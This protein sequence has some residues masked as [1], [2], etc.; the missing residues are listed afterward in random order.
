MSLGASSRWIRTRPTVISPFRSARKAQGQ[1]N[2]LARSGN[3]RSPGRRSRNTLCYHGDHYGKSD[4]PDIGRR[5]R[6]GFG[7]TGRDHCSHANPSRCLDLPRDIN[8]IRHDLA[9]VGGSLDEWSPPGQSMTPDVLATVVN[10]TQFGFVAQIR[11]ALAVILAGCLAYDRF[12]LAR[13][14]ALA[15]SLGLI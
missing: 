4:L 6:L 9:V 1:A 5:G 8:S 10:E 2:E 15:M 12:A 7:E 11:F 3:R 13:G 14:L